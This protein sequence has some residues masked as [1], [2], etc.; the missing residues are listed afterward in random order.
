MSGI[1]TIPDVAG[2]STAAGTAGTTVKTTWSYY[3]SINHSRIVAIT[4]FTLTYFLW[5]LL[6]YFS[7]HMYAHFCA[8]WSIFGF[9]LHPL[10]VV[11]PQCTA[12]RWFVVQ[13]ASSISQC[14]A[15]M[16]SFVIASLVGGSLN[17]NPKPVV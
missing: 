5:I 2:T 14:F 13:G 12:L 6:S 7:T 15:I 16:S 10:M 4:S 9:I 17:Q 8:E 3:Y 11:S 1:H